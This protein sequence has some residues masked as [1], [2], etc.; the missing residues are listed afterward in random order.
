ME[1]ETGFIDIINDDDNEQEGKTDEEV[2]L[3]SSEKKSTNLPPARAPSTVWQHYERIYDNEGIHIHTKCN[4]CDQKYSIKCST[5]TLNDHWKRK[6]LK[7]QPGGVGSIEAAFDN[8]RS[9]TKLQPEDHLNSLNKLVNWVIVECQPFRVVE[10]VSFREFIASLNSG[11]HVPSRHTIRNKIDEKYIHYRNNVIKLFQ[12]NNS[13]IAFTSDMWTSDTGAPYMVLTAH[14]INNE[15]NLKHA[16]IAFQRFP[17]PHTGLQIQKVTYKILQDFSIATKALAITIDNGANQVA[18]MK[19]LTT[20]LSNELQV[21]FNVIR[22]GAHSIALVVNAG[23]GKV[24]N[25]INKVRA[26]IIEIRKSPKKE[27]ELST[28]ATNL[29]FKY[30]KLIRDVKTRWNSTFSMLESFLANKAAIIS[31]TSIDDNFTKLDLVDDEW[32]ELQLFCDF[33]KPFFEFT[34][35]M[36]GSE[37]PTF[38]TLLILF[39]HL[40]EHITTI[41]N[42]NTPEIPQWIKEIAE[43]MKTKFNPISTNLYNSTAYLALV[44]DPRYKT[45]IIPNNTD[46][47]TVKQMLSEKYANYRN[48]EQALSVDDE[49]AIN[50]GTNVGDK[51]KSSG[52]LSRMI[53]KKKRVSNL[54]TRNEIAEYLAIPV[55]SLSIDPCE[56]WKHH[57]TQ[58]PLLEKMARDYICIPATSV[59]SEQAFSKSGELINKKRNRLGD[60]AIEACMCLNSWIKLLDN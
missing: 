10:S 45:Q 55:E 1:D 48:T 22:C 41:I 7:I 37:Y 58:Y 11:F 38:G 42:D 32:R 9:Q 36:S 26:F 53:Q 6:H 30:K 51:R 2:S 57:R 12:E 56:W 35:E 46:T 39:D 16:V 49:N 34:E 54:Q 50:E 5:T 8:A 60:R 23:L 3:N 19:L 28:F 21:D 20:T 13:K 24:R 14:W 18:A 25:I 4:Y 44:L 33:L 47:D 27:Q 31:I 52:I 29:R 17:H 40:L 59:P 43:D 15:W